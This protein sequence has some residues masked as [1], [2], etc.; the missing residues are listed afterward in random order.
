MTTSLVYYYLTNFGSTVLPH[1]PIPSPD[2][3]FTSTDIPL[4]PSGLRYLW[5]RITRLNTLERQFTTRCRAECV[6]DAIIPDAVRV[7]GV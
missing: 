6:E 3:L 4:D 5:R 7:A 1:R 2:G